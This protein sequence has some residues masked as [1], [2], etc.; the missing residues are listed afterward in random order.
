MKNVQ[1]VCNEWNQEKLKYPKSITKYGSLFARKVRPLSPD[2]TMDGFYHPSTQQE[3]GKALF[4]FGRIS[5]L[6]Y[7]VWRFFTKT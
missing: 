3:T 5:F 2:P 6:I 4:V 1:Q 7:G